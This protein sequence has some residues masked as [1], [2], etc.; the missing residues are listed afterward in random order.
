METPWIT[1]RAERPGALL[2]AMDQARGEAPGTLARSLFGA[3]IAGD[4]P[5]RGWVVG[6]TEMPSLW[7]AWPGAPSSAAAGAPLACDSAAHVCASV[8]REL[9]RAA[10]FASAHAGDAAAPLPG[11]AIA[12]SLESAGL[13]RVMP[14]LVMRLAGIAA[15]L[16]ETGARA[17]NLDPRRLGAI[18]ADMRNPSVV[19]D[20]TAQ[21]LA[22]VTS[23]E[24]RW[25]AA[26][27]GFRFDAEIGF[28]PG[29][30]TPLASGLGALAA[31]DDGVPIA[32][33]ARRCPAG[34]MFVLGA[35]LPRAEG[36]APRVPLAVVLE[37]LAQGLGA[38][39]FED[40]LRAAWGA[41]GASAVICQAW[42]ANEKTSTHNVV[43]LR[44]PQA[45]ARALARVRQATFTVG[46][47]SAALRRTRAGAV[48]DLH[49][50]GKPSQSLGVG[51]IDGA[52]V[53]VLG[54]DA[55]KLLTNLRD[56]PPLAEPP[57]V[58]GLDAAPVLLGLDVSKALRV[59]GDAVLRGRVEITGRGRARAAVLASA[60]LVAFVSDMARVLD[61]PR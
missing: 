11:P 26:A 61:S 24:I 36:G 54:D 37:G 3:P 31:L 38:H 39:D 15:S 4:G 57:L 10:A 18:T 25:S 6:D 27:G 28:D 5:L 35:R 58:A 32:T 56:S 41:A 55:E 50:S 49:T 42:T 30:S 59:P 34:S 13:Q 48:L 17:K 46:S 23:A 12:I 8:A 40:V 14:R 16:I 33:L 9:P 2:D 43:A 19:M 1:V 53:L 21:A 52:L 22:D 29:G 60:G 44:D 20:A 45:A 51:L 7:I 47:T